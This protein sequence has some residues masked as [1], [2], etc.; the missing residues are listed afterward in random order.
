M[1]KYV[2]NPYL[3]LWEYVP[4][5]E[6]RVFGDRLYVYGSHDRSGGPTGRIKTPITQMENGN[7]LRR[8][9][10]RAEMA[11]IT[12]FTACECAGNLV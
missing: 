1:K 6:P 8:M 12:F 4:D 2:C 11:G 9:W 10:C 5:G 3:P 7:C